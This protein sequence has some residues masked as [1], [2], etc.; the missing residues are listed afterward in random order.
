MLNITDKALTN[1]ADK[2]A[3]DFQIMLGTNTIPI[4]IQGIDD[5]SESENENE[6]KVDDDYS[7]NED[8]KGKSEQET[9]KRKKIINPRREYTGKILIDL[10]DETCGKMQ[11]EYLHTLENGE[12]LKKIDLIN[13]PKVNLTYDVIPTL[14]KLSISENVDFI[15]MFDTS[16]LLNNAA[17]DDNT[18]MECV[19]EKLGEWQQYPRSMA[20]FDV[21][22]LIGVTENMSDSTMGQSNSYSITN[23]RLWQQ[24]VIQT[25]NSK[26]KDSIGNDKVK[27]LHKWI[28]V[29]SK[30][31]FICKQFK[32][33]T[34]FPLTNNEKIE[35]EDGVKERRCK[36]CEMGY[37][38]AKNN[39]D[40]CSYHDGPLVDIRA[41]R[42]EIIHLDK[43][44]LYRN[45]VDYD[46]QGRQDMLKNFV[47][48]CCFQSYNSAGCK[49]NFHSD[50]KDNRDLKKYKRYF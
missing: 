33:L 24:V 17:F 37:T 25:A 35:Q 3:S 48:L 18:V 15:Q 43:N 27:N 7:E 49:K 29:I 11:L 21:D 23:N 4:L 45:F 13:L 40:S 19:M 36:N 2:V 31:Q 22:S 12:E 5:E 46:I 26:L 16:M 44:S 50:E 41:T 8:K 14:L 38:N 1:I 20:I 28:V 39:I 34:R 6:S 10:S 32:S 30:N 42:D 9:V 47:Y